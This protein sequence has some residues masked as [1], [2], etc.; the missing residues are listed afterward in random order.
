MFAIFKRSVLK[1]WLMIL[2]WGI[3]L[4]ILGYY[5]FDIYE[6][7]FLENVDLHQIIEAFPGEVMSFFGVEGMNIFEPEGFLH[8]E[9]F[10]YIPI[11]LGIMVIT[12]AANL[13]VKSEEEGTLEVILAQ[14]VSRSA[15]FWAKLLALILSLVLILVILW[16]G[17]ALGLK[18]AE[19]FDLDQKQLVLPLVS[20]FAVLLFFM[21]LAL[22]FSMILPSS[23]AAGLVTGFLLI[24]SFF[25]SSLVQIDETL[26]AINR[27]SPLKYYQGGAALIEL[28]VQ[29]LM[30]LLGFSI[31]FIASAW[32][33]FEKRD[34]R[35][36]GTGWLRLVLRK[37]SDPEK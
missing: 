18:N 3:G 30:L 36:G 4:A 13:I 6:T 2:G 27:F 12:N 9:F 25:I 32:F 19:A 34:M 35:F 1:N 5:L 17:F 10:S 26:E 20:L 24:A 14:P 16:T 15:I 23:S 21:S 22:L 11:I 31:L 33:L 8:L 28:N 7:L 29:D 37:E